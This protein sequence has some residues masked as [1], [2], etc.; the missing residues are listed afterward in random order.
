MFT[1]SAARR[2]AAREGSWGSFRTKKQGLLQ[3]YVRPSKRLRWNPGARGVHVL[4]GVGNGKVLLWEY[5]DGV[6]WCGKVAAEMYEGPLKNALEKEYPGRSSHTILEDN[7][8]TGFRSK[9]G[10]AA[11]KNISVKQLEIPKRSPQLNVCDYA[12]W[13]QINRRM[14]NQEKRFRPDYRESRKCFL[15]RLRRTALRLPASFINKSILNM[16]VRC[17]R[18]LAAEGGHIEEGGQ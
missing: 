16:K 11:K 7:D 1:T 5:I 9:A 14:R 15:A 6:R 13:D 17:Q 8:P 18:L 12:L 4:A 2:R 3:Q 10:M